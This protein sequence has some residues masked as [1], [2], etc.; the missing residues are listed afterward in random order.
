MYER[1]D[2]NEPINVSCV[3]DAIDDREIP[4]TFDG[5]VESINVFDVVNCLFESNCELFVSTATPLLSDVK[6]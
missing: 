3:D 4:R 6:T 1:D 2:D 5:V